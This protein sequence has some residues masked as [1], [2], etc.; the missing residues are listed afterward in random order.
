MDKK[1]IQL[2]KPKWHKTKFGLLLPFYWFKASKSNK[3]WWVKLDQLW[4]RSPNGELRQRWFFDD[5]VWV[6]ISTSLERDRIVSTSDA[7]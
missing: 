3:T 6:D 2:N 1:K 5:I 4:A 7:K